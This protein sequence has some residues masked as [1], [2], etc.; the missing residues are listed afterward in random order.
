MADH[1]FG[2]GHVFNT[3]VIAL[4]IDLLLVFPLSHNSIIGNAITSWSSS[5][6]VPP[7]DAVAEGFGMEK[8]SSQVANFGKYAAPTPAPAVVPSPTPVPATPTTGLVE[9]APN[10]I[11]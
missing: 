4:A 3:A 7:L 8:G 6:V 10:E 2:L 9:V 5:I 1:K 11:W